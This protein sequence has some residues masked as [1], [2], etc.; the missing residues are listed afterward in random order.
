[1]N[2]LKLVFFF[3]VHSSCL[4]LV[5]DETLPITSWN[6]TTGNF[7]FFFINQ[8]RASNLGDDE[9]PLDANHEGSSSICDDDNDDDG[10]DGDDEGFGCWSSASPDSY[11][12]GCRYW[13][14]S[15]SLLSLEAKQ[16][17]IR[18]AGLVMIIIASEIKIIIH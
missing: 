5:L 11:R 14:H 10:D 18:F 15:C 6:Y 8:N 16:V 2:A 1:M 7:F 17:W 3:F 13:W 12:Y 4:I 9:S